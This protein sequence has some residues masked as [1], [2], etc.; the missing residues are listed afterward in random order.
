[1]EKLFCYN[2]GQQIDDSAIYCEQCGMVPVPYKDLP[3]Y[4]PTDVSFTGTGNP[5][6]TSKSFINTNCPKCNKILTYSRI[7]DAKRAEKENSYCRSCGRIGLKH[8]IKKETYIRK[9]PNCNI[10]ILYTRQR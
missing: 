5:L 9:C 3:V 4:L 8:K 10:K 2:C 6:K 7:Y 1:M